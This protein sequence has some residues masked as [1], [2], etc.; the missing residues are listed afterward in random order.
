[1]PNIV[2]TPEPA[3]ARPSAAE[4]R[5][6]PSDQ[7]QELLR[8]IWWCSEIHRTPGRNRQDVIDRGAKLL[9]IHPNSL[10]RHWMHWRQQGWP[11][12]V[13]KE[14]GRPPK[15]ELVVSID[16]ELGG[17]AQLHLDV[18]AK[19][20]REAAG[21]LAHWRGAQ[22]RAVTRPERAS[23]GARVLIWQGELAAID[24]EIARR[25]A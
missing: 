4:L 6:V 11:R 21:H 22:A 9:G 18:L 12:L 23:A 13:Q 5:T 8:R 17:I 25:R 1:M 24:R 20:R 19:R 7:R 14:G 16:Q 3:N 10:R 15:S 2:K